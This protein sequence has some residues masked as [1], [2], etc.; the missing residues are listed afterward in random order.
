MH[1]KWLS[2][3]NNYACAIEIAFMCGLSMGLRFQI[4]QVNKTTAHLSFS[5]SPLIAS[6]DTAV[7]DVDGGVVT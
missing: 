7:A 1:V 5:L 4:T 6:V 2:D 3:Y